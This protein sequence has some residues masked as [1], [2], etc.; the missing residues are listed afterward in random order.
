MD[1]YNNFFGSCSKIEENNIVLN[2]QSLLN[3]LLLFERF[4][5]QSSNLRE[6]P[7]FVE[8]FGFEETLALLS[9]G[10]LKICLEFC[11]TSQVAQNKNLVP[12]GKVFPLRNYSISYGF[13]A[14]KKQWISENLRRNVTMTTLS[15][16]Q[17]KKLKKFVV[18][19]L[20]Q[21]YLDSIGSELIEQLNHDLQS[22]RRIKVATIIAL[23]KYKGLKIEPNDFSIKFHQIDEKVF[24]V[25]TN[26][27][28]LICL[29]EMELHKFV[30]TIIHSI[31]NLN[32][33]IARMKV[34]KAL[35]G[36]CDSETRILYDKLGFLYESLAPNQFENNFNRVLQLK[37]YQNILPECDTKININRLLEVRKS[38]EIREVR[39]WLRKIDNAKDS[40]I[41][42]QL[43]D[44]RSKLG[45]NVQGNQGKVSRFLV[46]TGIGC[47][48]TYG[49]VASLI[50]GAI[51]NFVL[52]KVL[53]YSG[54]IA[55]ID[56]MYPS[57]F[58]TT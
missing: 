25:E 34:S 56:K 12:G 26:L 47:I 29:D 28:K 18:N 39:E 7:H 51:D 3:K 17:N 54:I 2:K 20:E 36:F 16:K 58:E 1:I 42:E 43:N 8:I 5:L 32:I 33:R 46:S 57:L 55:F 50:L 41:M 27:D 4:I 35:L 30:E 24:K 9:S 44:I 53:P 6:I 45:V 23:N 48:P 49:T 52:D 21:N 14:D 11:L 13:T 19:A 15:K 37:K 22:N 40:E 10:A 38:N 31:S